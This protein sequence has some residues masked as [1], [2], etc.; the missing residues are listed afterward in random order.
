MQ[1][2]ELNWSQSLNT[3]HSNDR[4]NLE[5]L[6]SSENLTKKA[7]KSN[8]NLLANYMDFYQ[9]N[10]PASSFKKPASV[11]ASFNNLTL[12]SK[13][14]LKS[15]APFKN[16]LMTDDIQMNKTNHPSFGLKTMSKQFSSSPSL[17]LN[18]QTEKFNNLTFPTNYDPYIYS[19]NPQFS[20]L[21]EFNSSTLNSSTLNSPTTECTL[22]TNN[23]Q[24]ALNFIQNSRENGEKSFKT[25][26]LKSFLISSGVESPKE[27]NS[28]YC[29][30]NLINTAAS[31]N[32]INRNFVCLWENCNKMFPFQRDLVSA[33]K[34]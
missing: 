9:L 25:K 30:S 16:S 33:K 31:D 24:G 12:S 1:I 20:T 21:N 26:E 8:T 13:G 34:S 22:G 11:S 7:S 17:Q 32:Q 15:N 3:I 28:I 5:L 23:N 10:D 14:D 2:S 4:F 19:R 29:L 18:S 27:D 6:K